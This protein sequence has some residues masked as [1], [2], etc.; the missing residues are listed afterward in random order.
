[1]K[2]LGLTSLGLLALAIVGCKSPESFTVPPAGTVPD[3]AVLKSAKTFRPGSAAG[4]AIDP[5]G[6]NAQLWAENVKARSFSIRPDPFALQPDERAFEL[7]QTSERIFD[8][9]GGW[10]V[11][12]VPQEEKVEVP[13]VEPQPF[14]RL[15]GVIVADSI[16]ALIDMGDGKLELIKPGQEINGW[17]VVS[18]DAE[19]AVLRRGGNKLPR[20]I[21]VP[22]QSPQTFPGG[23]G[24]GGGQPAGGNQ[25]GGGRGRPGGA[26]PGA[27]GLGS[28]GAPGE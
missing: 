2:F 5:P 9:A 17:Q 4:V 8:T 12:F 15:A 26:Q 18:I 19:K 27:P 21:T 23:Q 28:P 20:V 7:D 6:Q 22:L 11:D 10:G 14:R 3:G 16:M 24:Q 25:P 13:Q 1:M